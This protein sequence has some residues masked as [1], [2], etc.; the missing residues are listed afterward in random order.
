[1]ATP[2]ADLELSRSAGQ[3]TR[4]ASSVRAQ[5]RQRREDLDRAKGLAI[6]LVVFGH[7]VAREQPLGAEWYE[8]LKDGI[9]QFHMPFF[10]YLSG[11][12]TFLSG[13][14][15][16]AGRDWPAFVGKRA[17]RLLIPFLLFGLMIVAGKL[18]AARYIHV[19]NLPESPMSAL[20]A[21][22]WDTDRSPALSVWY[23][24]VL[25]VMCAITPPLMALVRGRTWVL[26][27]IALILYAAPVPH[28]MYLNR[29]ATYFP[30]FLLGGL[31]AEGSDR[32]LRTVD[33]STWFALAALLASVFVVMTLNLGIKV[34]LLVCGIL[35][36]PALHGLVRQSPLSRSAVLL[37]LGSLS[38]VIYL[39]NTPFIGT[40]KGVLLR[41]FSWDYENFLWFAPVLMLAGILGP[42]ATKRWLL[43]R[44]PAL[45]KMT[46]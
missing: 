16:V 21:L 32:W 14:A 15:R 30:F 6:L 7:I 37:W 26:V 22:I 11:Y 24:A 27:A 4:T 1:M 23:I 42:I 40:V 19:D 39:L 3:D 31:A 20:T 9:Y 25:F 38:F 10:M 18:L 41:E 12:V 35:S 2:L 46:S 34:G 29:V 33:R 8:V 13:S 43:S 45:D 5:P 28:V 44:V 36:M 17:Y